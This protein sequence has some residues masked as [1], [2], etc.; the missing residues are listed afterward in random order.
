MFLDPRGAGEQNSLR[1]LTAS[2][3]PS[4]PLLAAVTQRT[5][6]LTFLASL[7]LSRLAL[8]LKGNLHAPESYKG[9]L[10]APTGGYPVTVYRH[11]RCRQLHLC[12]DQP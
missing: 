3:R 8:K 10:H 9:D 2:P 7:T 5:L 6:A 12:C 11:L 4:L 1:K